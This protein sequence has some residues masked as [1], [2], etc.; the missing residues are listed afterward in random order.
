MGGVSKSWSRALIT[1]VWVVAAALCVLSS[2]WPPFGHFLDIEQW[3]LG[4]ATILHAP[5][6]CERTEA[7]SG[8][9]CDEAGGF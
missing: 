9:Y 2:L 6:T 5:G 4:A 1:F 7:R 8:V 3:P